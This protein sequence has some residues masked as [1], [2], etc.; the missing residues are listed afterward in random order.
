M[1]Q[2]IDLIAEEVVQKLRSL[3]KTVATAESCTGGLLADRLTN[4]PGASAIFL[5]G[6]VSYSNESK[7]HL[8]D[9]DADLIASHGAVSAEVAQA[10]AEG[11][12]KISNASFG[13]ATTGIAGP[14]GG[15]EEKPVGTIF[16]AIA[17][18]N[19]ATKVWR[20]YFPEPRSVFKQQS[21]D[22]VLKRLF[23]L[24]LDGR[25]GGF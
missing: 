2:G 20:E 3:G 11:V 14:S 18:V 10:M 4:I 21:T 16:L 22:A 7:M 8:L 17:Q 12:Q 6:V 9:I 1:I 25:Q 13:L 15:S 23:L 5:E 19:K 24:L